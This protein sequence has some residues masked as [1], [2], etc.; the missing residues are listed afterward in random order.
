MPEVRKGIAL[1]AAHGELAFSRRWQLGQWL[2]AASY[3]QAIVLP[4]SMKAALVPWFA[5]IPRRTGYRGEMRYRVINDRRVL[6]KTVLDQTVKRFAA[7]G[8]SGGE[9]LADIPE[10][11]LQTDSGRQKALVAEFSLHTDRPAI[12]L[13]PGAEYGPAKCWPIEYFAELAGSMG[14]RGY[15]VWVLGSNNDHDA[16]AKIAAGGVAQNLCGKTELADVIDL[17]GLCRHAV[18]NDSGLLH[19]AAA[20]GCSVSAIYGSSSPDYTPPLTRRKVVHYL[21]LDCSPCFKRQCPL[22]HLRC[23]RDISAEQ[24]AEGIED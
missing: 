6:D 5:G 13:M 17:L 24:V 15:N 7:L 2:R 9:A 20:V 10:P 19:V 12:A 18:S 3:E 4:R 22:G 11:A 21:D 14:Q 8:M 23:L 16:G 1:P